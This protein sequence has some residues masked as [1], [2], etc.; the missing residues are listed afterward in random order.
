MGKIDFK[1]LRTH[2]SILG[3]MLF[4]ERPPAAKEVQAASEQGPEGKNSGAEE[5]E[6]IKTFKES[7]EFTSGY[8]VAY[9]PN[10]LNW[11]PSILHSR[12]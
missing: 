8:G 4:S 10:N 3:R 2:T 1:T 9:D 7:C 6:F 11:S 5:N 12:V